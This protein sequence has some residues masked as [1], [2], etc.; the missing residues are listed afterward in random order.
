MTRGLYEFINGSELT[1]NLISQTPCA[2]YDV[3][4]KFDGG[5]EIFKFVHDKLISWSNGNLFRWAH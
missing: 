2:K 4:W 5:R 3:V 1:P